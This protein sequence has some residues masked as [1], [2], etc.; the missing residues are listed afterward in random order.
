MISLDIKEVVMEKYFREALARSMKKAYQTGQKCYLDFCNHYKF[1]PFSA[2]N[3]T[4]CT[5]SVAY[6]W[7][8]T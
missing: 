8:T 4:W 7:P 5:S 6:M 2:N 3:V 1:H